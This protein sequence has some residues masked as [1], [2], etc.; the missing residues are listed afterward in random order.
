MPPNNIECPVG[1]LCN[2]ER[3]TGDPNYCYFE[4]TIDFKDILEQMKNINR[5]SALRSAQE[6]LRVIQLNAEC[7]KSDELVAAL[8]TTIDQIK[9]S[10]QN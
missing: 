4:G 5:P 9:A 7:Q 2:E 10:I 8:E 1:D 6:Q 3:Q